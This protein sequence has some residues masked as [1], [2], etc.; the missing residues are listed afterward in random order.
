MKKVASDI[1]EVHRVLLKILKAVVALC[2]KYNIRYSLY[3]GTLLGAVRHKGFI[4]W[5][6]DVDLT[7]PWEDYQL[8][9]EHADELPAGFIC[10]HRKNVRD[11]HYIWARVVAEGTTFMNRDLAALDI[12]GGLFVDIYP[13]I[14]TPSTTLGQKLQKRLIYVMRVLQQAPTYPVR[15]YPGRAKFIKMA[16]GNCPYVIRQTF[17]NILAPFCLIST[18]GAEWIGTIDSAPFEGKYRRENWQ[19]ME[20]LLFEDAYFLAPAQYHIILRRMYGNYMKL[21]P[22]EARRVYFEK[23]N[24]IIDPHRD[25]RL[26]R[27]ELLG[28]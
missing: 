12:P 28:K 4:P 2:E 11:F 17:I 21:P 8:F 24:M 6:H 9:L 10:I 19:Q 1:D 20:T 18:D 16:L 13:M 3:C 25:Y 14:G 15:N 26:Y 22:K 5:D 23:D 7:M 27:K